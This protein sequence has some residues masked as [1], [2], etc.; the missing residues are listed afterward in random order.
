[1]TKPPDHPIPRSPNGSIFWR[2]WW[3]AVSVKRSQAAIA[4][5]ALAV[6]A[7]IT[8]MLLNLY[9]DVRRKMTEDFRAYGANVIIAPPS[10]GDVGATANN[11]L[12]E[13]TT[14]AAL[15]AFT[16]DTPGIFVI[17]VLYGVVRVSPAAE[18][19]LKGSA[20]VVAVGVDLA[21]LRRLNPG[22]R[23]TAETSASNTPSGECSV[24]VNLA[25]RLR[26]RPGDSVNVSH[27]ASG[28]PLDAEQGTAPSEAS[29]LT[30]RVASVLTTGASE[31]DQIFFPLRALQSFLDLPDR[32]SLVEVSIPGET[33]EVETAVRRLSG[34]LPG[35]EVRPIRQIVYSEGKVLGTIRWLLLSLT[36]LI[37][38]II[39]L[40]V[41]ATMTAIVI[42]RG[43]D[44][45][46]MKALGAADGLLVRLFMVE[47]AS[48][49]LV[50]GILGYGAGVLL[51]R[52]LA[53]YLFGVGL[54][55]N[56]WTLP[57]VCGLSVVLAVTATQVPVRF[58]RVIQPTVVL[59]GE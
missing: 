33:R 34:L 38:V 59:K 3:R 31:D 51:A 47:G 42:E 15:A 41:M 37:L 40:C 14:S 30:Y 28:S 48:L 7:G 44:I 9:G 11:T 46:V 19:R 52:A 8:S 6:G 50:G 49:G 2:L 12:A 54:T 53:G 25:A 23:A 13:D 4:L 29:G 1:M 5:G 32:I 26:V 10:S 35:T 58:L 18:L 24:G 22:W 39:A 57:F 36:I 21:A 20:N 16:R 17:P 55:L 27:T 43:R 56:L 45:G